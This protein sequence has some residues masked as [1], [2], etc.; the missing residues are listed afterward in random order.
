MKI[1]YTTDSFWTAKQRQGHSIQEISYRACFKPQLPEFFINR[2]TKEGDLV[3]DPFGGRGTTAVQASLMMR[4]F[5][6][7]D[8]NPLTRILTEPRINPPSLEEIEERLRSIDL[9]KELEQDMDLTMFYNKRTLRELFALRAYLSDHPLDHVDQWIRMVATNRLTGH[10]K[11][12]F[13]VYTL[14]PN[15]AVSPEKQRKINEK[16]NNDLEEYRDIKSLI[17]KK[18]KSLLKD[19]D[20]RK[21]FPGGLFLNCEAH[22]TP[23]I[24]DDSVSLIV[25]SPPFLDIVNYAEDNWLRNWFNH[26]DTEQVN[27]NIT[28]LSSLQKWKE[29]MTLCFKEFQRIL[30]PEGVIAFEVGEVRNGKI[31]LEETVVEIAELL[32][33][34]VEEVLINEQTFTKTSNIW[35]VKNNQGGTNTNRIVVLRKHMTKQEELIK[36]LVEATEEG[37]LHQ[38]SFSKAIE[39]LSG[40]CKVIPFDMEQE[41]CREILEILVTAAKQI[42]EEINH[43]SFGQNRRVNEVGND[44]EGYVL[45]YLNLS[46]PGVSAKKPANK[47]GKVKTTGYPDLEMTVG[48]VTCYVECKTYNEK[49]KDSAL[50]SFYFQPAKKDEFKLSKDAYHVLLG[51]HLEEQK[52][53]SR[54]VLGFQVLS[55]DSLKVHLKPEFNASNKELYDGSMVLYS[56]S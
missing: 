47:K 32:G 27:R 51:F 4:P 11:G 33:L 9:D 54:G 37:Y 28:V 14:P 21:K 56:E 34:A 29:Y 55:L 46:K 15:Q 39:V 41:I 12:F 18:S 45:K 6:I 38:I 52:G 31:K 30:R 19:V 23:E 20:D 5:I 2:Y 53:G 44:M 13:S 35:G 7:N 24:Q 16:M 48:D 26:I 40:G 36:Q 10:S 50:R 17:L 1:K 22:H 3:Y 43:S 25:T 49:S 42:Q 8:V